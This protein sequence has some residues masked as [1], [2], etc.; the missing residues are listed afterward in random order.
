VLIAP[1]IRGSLQIT[2]FASKKV[3]VFIALTVACSEAFA[4]SV[5]SAPK[6]SKTAVYDVH[7]VPRDD[8]SGISYSERSRPFR[9]DVFAYDDWVRH[10]SSDR[11]AGRLG[12]LTKS[13]IVRSLSKEIALI[14]GAATFICLFNALLGSGFDDLAGIHQ[15]PL[16]S[17]F[18]VL[19]LPATFFTL[20]SP[21]LSLLL[22]EFVVF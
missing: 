18:P 15:G 20:S 22:G 21:A 17:G 14:A 10:R 19:S 3:L 2:M 4:P 12:K 9:R 8:G 7:T 13:G 5:F 11:F 16:I 1:S 6:V